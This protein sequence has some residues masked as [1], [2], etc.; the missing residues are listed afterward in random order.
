MQIVLIYFLLITILV[1]SEPVRPHFPPNFSK[2]ALAWFFLNESSGTQLGSSSCPGFRD[3][4]TQKTWLWSPLCPTS[5]VIFLP[6]HWLHCR[7]SQL[8]FSSPG[9]LLELNF[10]DWSGVIYPQLAF[11]LCFF[12]LLRFS[13]T[14]HHHLCLRLPSFVPDYTLDE[15]TLSSVESRQPHGQPFFPILFLSS[16][17][18]S[19]LFPSRKL[20]SQNWVLTI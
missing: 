20:F 14:R 4:V 11:L 9:T 10:H 5:C 2:K 15:S 6:S 13:V 7:R 16:V 12:S 1:K 17:N 18:E 3:T 19:F 8:G